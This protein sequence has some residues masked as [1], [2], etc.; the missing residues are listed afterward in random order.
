MGLDQY[1]FKRIEGKFADDGSEELEQIYYWRKNYELNDW[2]C[3]NF[4]PD[5]I[6]DFNCEKIEL[7]EH[8]VENLIKHIIYNIEKPSED[9]SGY[10]GLISTKVFEAFVDIKKRIKSGETIFYLAWW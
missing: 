8:L 2:A 3:C 4:C 6:S 9:E 10:E 1:I 5:H 7:E